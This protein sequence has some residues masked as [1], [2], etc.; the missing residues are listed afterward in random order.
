MV[1]I[2]NECFY[3]KIATNALSIGTDTPVLTIYRPIKLLSDQDLYCLPFHQPG[4]AVFS[5]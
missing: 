2:N 1:L 4:A 3:Q 5:G